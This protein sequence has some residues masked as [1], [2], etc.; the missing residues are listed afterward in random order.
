MPE[1]SGRQRWLLGM[2]LLIGA[3]LR[4]TYLFEVARAPDFDAPQFEAQYHDYWARALLSG[5]WTPPPGVTDPEIPHRP[6]FR[7]PG[8]PFALAAIY[9]ATGGG[10]VWPRLFQM[11]LG[12]ISCWLLYGLASRV[13]GNAAALGSAAFAATYWLFI[14]FEAELMAVTLLILLLLASLTVVVRWAEGFTARRAATVGVLLGAATL[15]RPNAAVLVPLFL[16]WIAW[17][18]GRR[19][20]RG[21]WFRRPFLVPSLVL[22]ATFVL[23]TLPA[24]LRNLRVSGDLVWITSN[25][26][27]NLFVGTHPQ[28]DGISP[29]VPE[30]GQISGLERGWDS[31]DYPR[32]AAGVERLVGRTMSDS[33]VSAYF[34]QRAIGY[35]VA[36]PGQ[37]LRLMARKLALFWGP[38]TIS[39]NKILHFERQNS[40]TLSFGPSFATLLAFAL[41]GLAWLGWEWRSG[42]KSS[43]ERTRRLEITVLLVLCVVVYSLS[44]LPF[45]VSDRFRAPVV[46][47]LILFAGYGLSALVQAAITARYR[48]L[49]IG[50]VL[51]IGARAL[52]GIAWVPYEPDLSLWHWRKG[53][54]WK[55]KGDTARAHDEFRQAVD[56]DPD[57]AEARLSF[58]ESLAAT[59]QFDDAVAEYRA[60]LSLPTA[61]DADSIVAHN[62]LAGLLARRGDIASAIQHWTAILEID[63]NRVSALNNLAYALATSTEPEIHDPAGA[64]ELAE[65]AVELTRRQDPRPLATLAVAYHAAGREVE[66]EEI[67]RNLKTRE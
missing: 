30:L 16:L 43:P 5:D 66:A 59:G 53:L 17:L 61:L 22:V 19:Q 28:S 64:V 57:D 10:Y 39:N 24:T 35:A 3:L 51:L 7:P 48:S 37:V 50:L 47:L 14:F 4:F 60:T 25:A 36:D 62:N 8:Y 1:T 55:A 58:A 26:G 12:L 11:V 23:A 41:V 2:I 52:T 27:V 33:E 54:L 46:P 9:A 21:V 44:F 13:Y 65:R 63:P 6:Y 32:V 40:P 15:V 49:T 20:G 31:F 34:S 45:F 56:A 38:A 67:Q 18:S 29:V 42:Q